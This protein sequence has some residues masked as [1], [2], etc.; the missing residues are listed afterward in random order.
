MQSQ[1][2]VRLRECVSLFVAVSNELRR[3][4]IRAGL[5]EDF[6]SREAATTVFIQL[7]RGGIGGIPCEMVGSNR[8]VY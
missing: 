7:S 3:Q 5:P 6:Y 4:A 8:I 1:V 2:G